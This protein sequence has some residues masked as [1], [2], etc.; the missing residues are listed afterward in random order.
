MNSIKLFHL[1]EDR[2][3]ISNSQIPTLLPTNHSKGTSK[4]VL[5]CHPTAEQTTK[6]MQHIQYR[7]H[8]HNK[9]CS[10]T[11]ILTLMPLIANYNHQ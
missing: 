6:R 3:F 9:Q 8:G 10:G 5:Y 2:T 4:N 1:P 7:H 11:R